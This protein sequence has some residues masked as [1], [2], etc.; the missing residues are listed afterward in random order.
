[1]RTPGPVK[2]RYECDIDRLPERLRPLVVQLR[3]DAT[4]AEYLARAERRR[5]SPL[6]MTVRRVLGYYLSDF[7][8]DGL[9]NSYPMHLASAAQWRTLLGQTSGGRL[10]DVGAGSGDVTAELA[11]SFDEV[12]VTETARVLGWRLRRRGFV[13]HL[14]DISEAIPEGAPYDAVSLLNVID[15]C[16]QPRALL[17]AAINALRNDG[18]LILAVPLP[19]EPVAYDGP[20]PVEPVA[21]LDCPGDTWEAAATSLVERCL[22]PAGLSVEALARVPYLAGGDAQA[23]LTT[24]DDVVLVC[25]RSVPVEVR[26]MTDPPG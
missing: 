16:R 5:L 10:L 6:G 12:H 11:R 17:R 19:Y 14:C 8:V 18:R 2:L 25:R 3:P 23:H 15:R 26:G 22:E 24:H 20:Y 1:V 13:V 21:P 7:D 4:T 9:L